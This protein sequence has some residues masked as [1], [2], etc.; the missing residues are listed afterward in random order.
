MRDVRG[1]DWGIGGVSRLPKLRVSHV[2]TGLPHGGAQTMLANIVRHLDR[3]E[4]EQSVISLTEV[5]P[6]GRALSE[7]G[8]SVRGLRMSRTAPNPLAMARLANWL[9][10]DAP[11]IVQTWMYHAD[12]VGGLAARAAGLR[13]IAWNIRQTDLDPLTSKKQTILVAKTC[14]RLSPYVPRKIVCCSLAS[15]EVHAAL[16]FDPARMVV[17]GNG[18]DTQKF[19]PCAESFQ[20]LRAELGM[21]PTTPV[22]GLV[23]RF[24]PQK[25]HST[26]VAAAA[27]VASRHPTARFVLVGEGVDT[28][29]RVIR[30]WIDATGFGS[31]FA[32]LGLRSDLERLTPAMDV[33]VSS[34]SYGEGFSNVLIEAMACGVPCVATNVGDASA[35]LA[36]ES[37]VV[38]T[39]DPQALAD[40]INR[41]LARSPSER[42]ALSAAIRRRAVSEFSVSS[43]VFRYAEFYRRLAA[44]VT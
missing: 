1:G 3:E 42:R 36:D 29:N 24:H 2:I 35:I 8:F 41:I 43:S 31:R 34:S 37:C 40:A 12:L 27:L 25:D 28:E 30:A 10:R 22:V 5:G 9:K 32:L 26:F 21:E 19:S 38:P 17:I 18:V 13:R 16:G 33:A 4:F 20:R 11:A 14:A 7:E 6:V 44:T 15:R 23:A 39:R